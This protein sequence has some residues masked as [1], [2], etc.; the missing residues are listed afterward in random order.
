MF[1]KLTLAGF[2][3]FSFASLFVDVQQSVAYDVRLGLVQSPQEHENNVGVNA[4]LI[5]PESYTRFE[6]RPHVGV[7]INTTGYTSAIYTGM[8]VSRKYAEK[9]LLEASLGFSM[10][11]GRIKRSQARKGRVLGSRLLFR[12]SLSL[13]YFYNK[14]DTVS[15]FIDHISNA[16]IAPP[17]HGITNLGVRFGVSI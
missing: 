3:I 12:E 5:F 2:F 10:H 13:G 1:P 17:N 8:L 14:S 7:N 11:N 16:N 15:L 9:Y 6:L 4:E